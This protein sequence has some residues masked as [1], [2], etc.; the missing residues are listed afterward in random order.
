MSLVFLGLVADLQVERGKRR[1]DKDTVL[2]SVPFGLLN[3]SSR[4]DTA[5][6]K[7]QGLQ[8]PRLCGSC[9]TPCPSLLTCKAS[10]AAT[11]RCKR[12]RFASKEDNS[13]TSN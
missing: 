7:M 3:E 8:P 6:S 10:S 4:I 9:S 1:W 13:I 11:H 5:H 12:V 2:I